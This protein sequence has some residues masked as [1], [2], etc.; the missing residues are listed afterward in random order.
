MSEQTC[1][2]HIDALIFPR[3]FAFLRYLFTH[4]RASI[5]LIVSCK[6]K[7]SCSVNVA[8]L[9]CFFMLVKEL[10]S[11]ITVIHLRFSMLLLHIKGLVHFQWL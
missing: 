11:L 8:K 2:H 10:V 1:D 3:S 5:T 9:V 4:S 6:S 7:R